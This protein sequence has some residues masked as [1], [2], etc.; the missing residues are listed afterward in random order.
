MDFNTSSED[1]AFATPRSWEMVSNIL[2]Y[3]NSDIDKM[4]SMIGGLVGTGIAIEFKT[5]AKVYKDLPDIDGIF[6]GEMPEPPKSPDA[7]YALTSAMF[8]YAKEHKHQLDLITNS[9]IYAD[10]LPPDYSAML[11]KDY[12]YIEKGYN[13]KLL[14]IPQ[15]SKWL[16]GKGG[17]LNG[18][19][20]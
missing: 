1:L 17:L 3:V 4:Q 14:R 8:A 18:F 7:L 10:K 5:W 16:S 6:K 9:I 19:V 15:F 11:L 13:E 2:N 20:G 12:M